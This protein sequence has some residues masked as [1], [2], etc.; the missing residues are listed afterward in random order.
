MFLLTPLVDT[1]TSYFST[2][3]VS[4]KYGR[5]FDIKLISEFTGD[6]TGQLVVEWIKNVKL[7][8]ELCKITKIE[9]NSST[10]FERQ[11]P[12]HV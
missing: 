2:Y 1:Q 6:K 10:A 8:C 12:C 5:L 11:G 3:F 9:P 7:V 4:S